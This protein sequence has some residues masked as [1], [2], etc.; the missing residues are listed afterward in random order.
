MS[1]SL[2]SSANS[3]ERLS[4]TII[5]LFVPPSTSTAPLLDGFA[6]AHDELMEDD[7]LFTHRADLAN[8][9]V[10]LEASERK[11]RKAEEAEKDH[12]AAVETGKVTEVDLKSLLSNT[13]KGRLRS[14]LQNVR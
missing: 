2:P 9:K 13:R 6:A 14:R 1:T 7:S 12:E 8:G 4:S 5:P 11:L 10:N 3:L